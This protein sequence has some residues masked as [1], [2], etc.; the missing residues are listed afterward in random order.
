MLDYIHN[1][2]EFR[3]L[4]A[5]VAAKESIDI[6]LVEKD[7]KLKETMNLTIRKSIEVAE[8]AFNTRAI[9]PH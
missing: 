9:H 3:D 4:L 2:A 1:D 6:A 8:Y 7:S 5:I